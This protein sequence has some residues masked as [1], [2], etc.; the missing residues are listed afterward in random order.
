MPRMRTPQGRS[1]LRPLFTA[2]IRSPL[3]GSKS[4]G[5]MT[6]PRSPLQ[7]MACL[8]ATVRHVHCQ[9]G[10]HRH[11]HL[12]GWFADR[13]VHRPRWQYVYVRP[14]QALR[15][16]GVGLSTAGD[17]QTGCP[18]GEGLSQREGPGYAP[19][20]LLALIHRRA[21]KGC[22]PKLGLRLREA[23]PRLSR[24]LLWC[25]RKGTTRIRGLEARSWDGRM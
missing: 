11:P 7:G 24:L 2:R 21:W 8:T 17:G 18:I 5:I 1:A 23:L 13:H 10:L 6:M 19:A 4:R 12:C 22:S 15:A 20:L 14:D 9:G 16:C 25:L 3:M